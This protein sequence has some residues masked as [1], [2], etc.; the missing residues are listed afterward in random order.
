MRARKRRLITAHHVCSRSARVWIKAR[1]ARAR[2]GRRVEKEGTTCGFEE[3]EKKTS[4]VFHITLTENPHCVRKNKF[5]EAYVKE[6]ELQFRAR[7][8]S[9]MA[10]FFLSIILFFSEPVTC[11]LILG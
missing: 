3:E 11:R 10:Y 6:I 8:A 2:S 1:F 7:A 9:I 4:G 5:S